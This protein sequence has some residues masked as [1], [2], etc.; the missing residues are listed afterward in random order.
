[1]T[2]ARTTRLIT[3]SDLRGEHPARPLQA[4]AGG[5]EP[6][7]IARALDPKARQ[8]ADGSWTCRCPAHNDKRTSLSLAAEEDGTLS[9]CC[10]AS[11]SQEAVLAELKR[12]GL[13]RRPNGST[14]AAKPKAKADQAWIRLSRIQKAGG[15]LLSKRI[16]P[17][18][19]GRPISDAS[20]CAMSSGSAERV[21]LNGAPASGLAN[22]ILG[23]GSH[24]ALV[25]GDHVAAANQIE[26]VKATHTDPAKGLYGR[27]L[28]TFTY[29]KGQPAVALLD[30]DQKA[31]TENARAKIEMCGGFEGGSH[32]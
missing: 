6:E 1:M 15:A 8:L 23:L 13:L 12:R 31:I 14:G 5:G 18:K 26:I 24:E 28:D 17:G 25:L 30:Y 22:L 16:S 11:C 3:P 4:D 19:D 2:G 20:L 10:Y 7:R 32:R 27:T 29:R 21:V 9:W